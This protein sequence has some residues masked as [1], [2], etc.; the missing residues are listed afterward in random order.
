M[1]GGSEELNPGQA[2][3]LEEAVI[4]FTRWPAEAL[5][6]G[7]AT[8]SIEI[9]KSA[10]FLFLSQDLFDVDLHQIHKTV[11]QSVY[12]RGTLVHSA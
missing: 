2:L 10:D 8:G 7:D 11:A 3:S 1:P 12:L 6:L 9:G 5:G 4:S